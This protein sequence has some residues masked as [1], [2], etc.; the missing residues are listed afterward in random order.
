MLSRRTLLAA[1]TALPIAGCAGRPAFRIGDQRNG[2]LLAARARGAVETALADRAVAWR[3]FPS[4]PP[5]LEALSVGGGVGGIDL[6]G[7]GDTPPI[8]SQY[9]GAAIVY[10]AAQ[11]VS[12]DAAAI[13]VPPASPLRTAADLRGAKVAFT[14]ASSS[15]RFVRAAL[16]TVG[17]DL[18]DIAPINL[19]P[20]QAAT[21]FAARAVDAWA[22]WDP[23][24][25]EAEVAGAR[26][27]IGGHGLARA[28]SFVLANRAVAAASPAT[29]VAALDAL[30][31]T[32]AW[33]TANRGDLAALI[34]QAGVRPAVAE[35]IARRQDVAI[36]PLTP[37]VVARQQGIA[38]DLHAAGQLPSRVPV[39]AAMWHG[40]RGPTLG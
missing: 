26:V 40:W 7:T 3:D 15:Q 28:D 6:G 2:L 1:A 20:T 25:A 8:F 31:A 36:E 24:L 37:A 16:A 23:Y 39:A 32:A 12:G 22:T 18:R 4:G 30:A 35:R 27:L 13:V 5:L 34:A 17:L 29:I 21:A 33:A 10:V 38:D 14:R 19:T 11:P 9:A